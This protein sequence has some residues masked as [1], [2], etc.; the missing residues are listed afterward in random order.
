M[1][2]PLVMGIDAG[3]TKTLAVVAD[4]R[5]RVLGYGRSS[6]ANIYAGFGGAVASLEQAWQRALVPAG[7][8][9]VAHLA[10]SATGADWSEDFADLRQA[11]LRR[12]LVKEDSA[13]TVVNDAV[14]ALWTGSATGEGVAVAVGTSAGTAARRGERVWHSSFWQEPEGAVQLGYLALRAV[15]R[16]ELGLGPPTRLTET[17]LQRFGLPDVT[18]LLHAF[19]AR[20]AP[21][22]AAAAGSSA[23]LLLDQAERG[24]EVACRLVRQ[25]AEALGDYAVVAAR[26]VG[27]DKAAF[28]LVLTGGVMRH[29]GSLLKDAL[30]QRVRRTLPGA[31]LRKSSFEPV[32]GAVCIALEA[33]GFHT[34]SAR[35]ALSETLPHATFYTT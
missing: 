27:L 6:S 17:F 5:G 21:L 18:T 32:G 15:Y 34:E 14:A 4:R 11:V 25:H 35:T 3:N 26:K 16:A 13:L 7:T 30:A 31:T 9:E 1:L 23:R 33:T 29:P 22:G 20:G 28:P 19:T 24:D 2:G 10:L 8:E 12:G